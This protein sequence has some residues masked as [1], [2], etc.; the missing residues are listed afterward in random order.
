ML[1]NA[2]L[3][4]PDLVSAPKLFESVLQNCRGRVD[5]WL[6]PYIKLSLTRFKT[7]KNHYLKTLLLSVVANALYY[8]PVVCLQVLERLGAT[9]E[10]FRTWFELLYQAGK[11]KDSFLHFRR[12]AGTLVL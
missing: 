12:W 4:E 11:K 10:F 2:D 6:E 8:N 9:G 5:N 7:A 3:R 1:N